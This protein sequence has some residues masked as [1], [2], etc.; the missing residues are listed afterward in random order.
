MNGQQV[1]SDGVEPGG[2]RTSQ[3]IKI[4]VCYMLM[5]AGEPMPRQAVLDIISG[6]GMANFFETGSKIGSITPG[7]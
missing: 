4:L 2:L 1:F 7:L 5:G 6:N 3:E